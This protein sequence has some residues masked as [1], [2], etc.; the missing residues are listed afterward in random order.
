M[1]SSPDLISLLPPPVP[2]A[3][4]ISRTDILGCGG[5]LGWPKL[6]DYKLRECDRDS[7][8]FVWRAGRTFKHTVQESLETCGTFLDAV[9]GVVAGLLVLVL[10]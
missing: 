3:Q 2:R 8:G 5:K 6:D 9:V 1:P 4:Y 10:L 7:F